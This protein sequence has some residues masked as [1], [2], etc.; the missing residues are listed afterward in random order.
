MRHDAFDSGSSLRT[1]WIG[2][3]VEEVRLRTGCKQAAPES[4][5]LWGA[6]CW[7]K[8]WRPPC[9]VGRGAGLASTCHPSFIPST[10][11][12][13][14][15]REK[16]SWA[17]NFIFA[18]DMLLLATSLYQVRRMHR[19]LVTCYDQWGLSLRDAKLVRGAISL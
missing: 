15:H 13:R 14:N 11:M 5:T 9:H 7:T 1:H 10:P 6:S 3:S 8:R 2:F 12:L 4:R 19:A 18:E 16:V 17:T